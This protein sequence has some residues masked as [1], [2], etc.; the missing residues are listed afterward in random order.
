MEL[1]KFLKNLKTDDY[2][3]IERLIFGNGEFNIPRKS[4]YAVI[5]GCEPLGASRRA[6]IAADLYKRGFA[7]KL[8]VSGGVTHNDN[9]A[10]RAE[11]EIMKEHLIEKG[12]REEDLIEERNAT[13]T[14]S[15]ITYSLAEILK[16]DDVYRNKINAVTVVTEPFHIMRSYMLAK[17]LF[18]DFIRVYGYTQNAEH[19]KAAWRTDGELKKKVESEIELLR[20]LAGNNFI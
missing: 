16:A 7:K 14:V 9:G 17:T 5:L 2:E 8:V 4:D 20:L 6:D 1:Q 10:Q 18:P 3:N 19:D 13:D 15:N 12:V 11:Y